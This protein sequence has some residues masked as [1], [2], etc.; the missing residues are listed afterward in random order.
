MIL[1]GPHACKVGDIRVGCTDYK[2]VYHPSVAYRIIREATREEW[3]AAAREAGG[4]PDDVPEE[5]RAKGYYYE[6]S[7]D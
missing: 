7:M 1:G 2:G 4:D 6:V 5:A 3:E